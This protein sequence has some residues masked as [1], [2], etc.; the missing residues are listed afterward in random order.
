MATKKNTANESAAIV[1]SNGF[2]DS[3][4]AIAM[5]LAQEMGI[6]LDDSPSISG[7][8]YTTFTRYSLPEGVR[9]TVTYFDS[10]DF[11]WN[12]QNQPSDIKEEFFRKAGDEL[13]PMSG[14]NEVGGYITKFELQPRLG[15]Y[16]EEE[17]KSKV[18][19]S[20]IGYQ[21]TD[22]ETGEQIAIKALPPVPLKGMHSWVDNTL[23][24]VT[25][26]PLVERLGLIGSRGETCTNCIKNGHSTLEVETR[27][28]PKVESCTA[29]GVLFLVVHELTKVSKRP[30]KVAGQDPE[31]V[32]T[33][34]KITDL[35]DADG[36]P[37]RP[38]LLAVNITSLGLRGAWSNEP[39][40]IGYFNH[41]SSLERQ[42]NGK[43]LRR[44]PSFHFTTVTL[45]KK[46]GGTKYQLDFNRFTPELAKVQE[47]LQ[48]WKDQKP[49][50][51]IETIDKSAYSNFSG[52]GYT[53]SA[54]QALDVE[55]VEP[56]FNFNDND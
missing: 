2:D 22:L 11:T 9:Y 36:N 48:M 21:T 45:R 30:S 6:E 37:K 44:N 14:F 5:K 49:N 18:T 26:D 39:K 25:P 50:D 40:I 38:C 13:I 46:A 32:K 51:V 41:I 52:K 31:E 17:K 28:G 43:D 1:P 53:Q 24:Y 19:C 55:V 42:F 3:E 33:T 10:G 35:C 23:S 20:V 47:S 29:R 8:N 12:D 7:A 15:T 16:S 56:R 4:L 34:Y 54:D 27:Q